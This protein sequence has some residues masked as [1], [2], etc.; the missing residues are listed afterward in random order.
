[1]KPKTLNVIFAAIII[2]LAG[3]FSFYLF[4][5]RPAA[6]LTEAKQTIL[7]NKKNGLLVEKIA[8]DS[9]AQINAP[10]NF[11]EKFSEALLQQ[12]QPEDFNGTSDPL[13]AILTSQRI[14]APVLN[15][16]FQNKETNLDLDAPVIDFQISDDNSVKAKKAFFQETA[17][18]ISRDF[19]GFNKIF[20]AVLIDAFDNND[21]SSA[22]QL[23]NIYEKLADDLLIIAPPRDFAVLHKTMI[24]HYQNGAKIYRAIAD[25]QN[26]PIKGYLASQA[27]DKLL[28]DAEQIQTTINKNAVA[29][30][31]L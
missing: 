7:N 9:L 21:P 4:Q 12:I 28:S 15:N 30:F 19:S 17:T 3:G 1:M 25:H 16:F 10:A 11:T 22:L 20:Y 8:S 13:S 27:I 23:A 18:V 14:T 2:G 24:T 26:D 29:L 6:D 5:N 31:S